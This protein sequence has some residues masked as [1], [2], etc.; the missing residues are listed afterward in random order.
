M[1]GLLAAGIALALDGRPLAG[2]AVCAL[3]ATIKV[4]ALAGAVFI[5]VAWA[6]AEASLGPGRG[7]C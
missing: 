5:A 3:A 4:P 6:R 7:F 1:I 2:I